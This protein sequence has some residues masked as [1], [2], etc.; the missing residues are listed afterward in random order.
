M[1]QQL[2]DTVAITD[3]GELA[4]SL[5]VRFR[6]IDQRLFMDQEKEVLAIL[7]RFHVTSGSPVTYTMWIP[8]IRDQTSPPSIHRQHMGA[9]FMC[10]C[11]VSVRE[12]PLSSTYGMTLGR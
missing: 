2:I 10:L 9:A 12:T 11:M 8:L 7:E 4:Y 3:L 5:G 1:K 6:W